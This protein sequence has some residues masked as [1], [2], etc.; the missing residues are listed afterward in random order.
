[1]RGNF[2]SDCH[3][4]KLSLGTHGNTP[5]ASMPT[6]ARPHYILHIKDLQM[7]AFVL[8]MYRW[9]ANFGRLSVIHHR[10][11]HI[12]RFLGMGPSQGGV[13]FTYFKI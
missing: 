2:R 9:S 7:L 6:A 5:T 12:S 3:M 1:M 10:I 13:Y 11:A 8:A 4:L